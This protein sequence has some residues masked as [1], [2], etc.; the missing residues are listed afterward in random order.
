[1]RD[2]PRRVKVPATV[3]RV[4]SMSWNTTGRASRAE[5]GELVARAAGDE[6]PGGGLEGQGEGGEHV[7]GPGGGSRR[8]GGAPEECGGGGETDGRHHSEE[9]QHDG[10]AGIARS[11]HPLILSHP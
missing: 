2:G 6:P 3:L 11:T 4:P 1:M 8:G 5:Q 7:V 10:G 9:G